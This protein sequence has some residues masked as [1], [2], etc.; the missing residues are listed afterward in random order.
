[1]RH[2]RAT[3]QNARLYRVCVRLCNG[4]QAPHTRRPSRDAAAQKSQPCQAWRSAATSCSF[5]SCFDALGP[6][7]AAPEQKML[8]FQY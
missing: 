5:F 6:A 8:A 4:L 2:A 7:Q 1:M 3:I